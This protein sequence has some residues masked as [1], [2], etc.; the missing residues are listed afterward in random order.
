MNFWLKWGGNVKRIKSQLVYNLKKD[1][2]SYISFGIVVLITAIMLNLALVLVF[3]VDRAYDNKF[4]DLETATINVC[5]PQIQDTD[6]LREDVKGLEG[7]SEVE[8]REAVFL[9]AVVK[10]FRGTDFSMNTVF[11]NKD[12]FRDMNK[13]D[14]KEESAESTGESI[15]LPLYVA[16]FGKFGL[17]DKIIYEIGDRKHTFLISG[18]LEEMQYGNYGKGLMGAYLPKSVYEE[19]A[20]EYEQHMVTEYSII[21]NDNTEI[22]FLN[23]EISNLLE[24]KNITMLTSCDKASTKDTRIMVCDLLILVLLAFALVILLVSVFLCKFRIRNSIEEDMVNMGVLKALGY[25]GNMIIG[26]VV[27]PYLMVTLIA[28]LLG[29][30]ASYGILPSLSEL[31]T[32]QAGFSF[33]LLFDIKGFICVEIIL[34]F[35]VTVFTYAAAKR[36]RKLQPINAIRGNSGGK[37]IKKNYF[38]LEETHG[39]A[40]LLLVLKLLFSNGKQNA[41][42]FGVFFVLTI[43]IAFAST[44]FYNVIVKPNNFISTL[45]EEI[46][47]IIIYPKEQY[48]AA[49]LSDLQS[50]SEIKT[51]LKYTMG[52]VNIDD[53]PVTVFA[54]EDFSKVSNDLCYLGENPNEKNEI[55]L[56]SAFEGKYKLGEQ[57]EIQNG[58]VSCSYEITGFVQSVNYQGNVCEF[59]MEGYAAL[60][61]ETIVP[62]LYVY[63]QDWTDVERYIEEIEESYGDTIF[64]QVNYKKMTETTQEMYSGITSIIVIVIFVLTILIALFVLYIVIKTLLVQ[65]KQELGIYKA[66]GYSNWQLMVQL[67]GSFLPSSVLAV[68]LSSGL[69]LIYVP[70]INRFIFQTIGAVKNNMEVSFT[71]LMIFALIQIVVNLIISI[72]LIKPIKKISAY[73]LI[74]EN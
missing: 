33:G 54:C 61:S 74:K 27:L 28:S 63:L 46:P 25:T 57:I 13:L 67:M 52:T 17:G 49:L 5:I 60:N 42:L 29:V 38:P 7:V 44:L 10:D 40:K 65:R 55:A 20:S 16:S 22:N 41:L 66:I 72:L 15:Y 11:Y 3:Q 21:A 68:L 62:S 36:I 24:E 8:C 6:T 30:I 73:A 23:N 71:F 4:E 45:S 43:L 39:N 48:E 37:A 69:G 19:F 1:K 47:E 26:S 34:V 50:D 51:V 58:D 9:E 12:E 64:N 32:L 18:V 35:I 59:S 70:Q 14:I 53:V 2:E 31:L 56:G